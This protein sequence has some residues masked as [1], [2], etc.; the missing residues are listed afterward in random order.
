VSQLAEKRPINI[1]TIGPRNLLPA[2]EAV[3]G[4]WKATTMLWMHAMGV[5]VLPGIIVP[6]WSDE[7]ERALRRF[8]RKNRFSRVLLRIDKP[9]QRW[10]ARR[11]GYLLPVSE[12]EKTVSELS[13][14][15]M[16]AVLL[17][18]AGPYSNRYAL[19]A[20]ALPDEREIVVEV[21]GP[22][23]DA[24]DILRNDLQPHERFELP[25]ATL[26]HRAPSLTS[27]D[28][29]RTYLVG[30][31]VYRKSV[32]ERLA[33]IGARLESPAFPDEVL[34]SPRV[35]RDKLISTATKYLDESGQRCLL[36]HL[37]AYKPIPP[38]YFSRFVQ[39]VNSLL[40]GLASYGIHLGAT[41]ISSSIIYDR[42]LI[43]WDFFPA[44]RLDTTVL[45]PK[46]PANSG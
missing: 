1:G 24:S 44:K 41:S 8:S 17:E 31:A 23:F 3:R 34:N 39:A 42:R 40:N 35:D 18:P 36:R 7:S 10:T 30:S 29:H 38:V 20:L 4:C 13:R 46:A 25:L 27:N 2:L 6:I 43:F 5:P 32:A 19:S 12:V 37:T 9:G 45:A 11:G 16:I 14:E 21:V 26:A 22:G 15:G 33:K 28:C